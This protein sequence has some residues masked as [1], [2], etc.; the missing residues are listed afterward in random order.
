MQEFL[1]ID[2]EKEIEHTHI[3]GH[4]CVRFVTSLAFQDLL[5]DLRPL[6]GTQ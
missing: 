1:F 2:F 6:V 4:T 5:L 3:H